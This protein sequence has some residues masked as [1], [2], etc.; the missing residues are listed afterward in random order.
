MTVIQ[1]FIGLIG[2][3]IIVFV[4]ELGHFIAAKACGIDV[5]VFSLGWGKKLIGF[6]RGG[7]TYQISWFLIGGYCKM[8]GEMP[9][10]EMSDDEMDRL[11]H[12]PGAFLAATPWQRMLVGAAG[13][14][15]NMI[16]A[17]V[18]LTLIWW[19][20]FNVPSAEN[21]IILASDYSLDAS[22][23]P[24]PAARAG[25]ETGDRIVGTTER[26][27]DSFWK[28]SEI[29]HRNAGNSLTFLVERPEEGGGGVRT[30][31]VEIT[32]EPDPRTGQGR[33]GVYGWIDPVIGRVEPGKPAERAGLQAGDVIVEAGGRTIPHQ[34]A[35]YE[36][37]WNRPQSVELEYRRGKELR[38][39]TLD[40]EY[41]RRG[42]PDPGFIFHRPVFRTPGM[43][44]VQALGKG[45]ERSVEILT[46]TARGLWQLVR[47]RVDRLEEVVA[48]PIRITKMVGEA[49][50]GGF[51]FGLEE[52]FISFFQFLCLL[53]IVIAAMNLLPIPALDG[54]LIVLSFVEAVRQRPLKL[55]VIYR[56]Q[57]VGFA[58]V[59]L[60][61]IAALLSD[62]LFFVG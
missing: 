23:G 40:L 39:T 27:I 50:T 38:S 57:V 7:T 1:V 55:K 43:N 11:R 62:I 30:L 16:F 35:F 24:L 14:V 31:Q 61:I 19:I 25:L 4:H 20:G 51:S 29:V 21:R 28:L 6:E 52:G 33:I 41:D 17:V 45:L 9:R 49:A 59:F 13:P 5:E 2:L 46:L 10:G 60:I 56:F 3:G 44:A 26:S 32:P 48:G 42:N 37:L 54:G 22:T 53:S 58:I 18:V 36:I 8:K 47:L 15:S 12:E 34:I